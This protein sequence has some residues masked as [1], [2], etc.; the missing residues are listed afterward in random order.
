MKYE[1]FKARISPE[2][3]VVFQICY[4][5]IRKEHWI[6][7][8]FQERHKVY[9]STGEPYKHLNL[10][11]VAEDPYYANYAEGAL[12]FLTDGYACMFGVSC[13]YNNPYNTEETVKFVSQNAPAKQVKG[14]FTLRRLRTIP[15]YLD[16]WI[17]SI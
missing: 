11:Y 14:F 17:Q 1:E 12:P 5:S 13:Y 9:Y 8:D 16:L 2:K 4:H 7:I 10:K 3:L 6:P 15:E